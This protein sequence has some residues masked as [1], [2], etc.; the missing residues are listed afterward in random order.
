[1]HLQTQSPEIDIPAKSAFRWRFDVLKKGYWGIS[2]Y[3]SIVND[4][5]FFYKKSVLSKAFD[6]YNLTVIDGT[7]WKRAHWD[8]GICGEC[9]RYR[10]KW[11]K[12][13]GIFSVVWNRSTN[14]VRLS[15]RATFHG[16]LGWLR[17]KG[18]RTQHNWKCF[19]CRYRVLYIY[20]EYNDWKI[21]LQLNISVHESYYKTNKM[22]VSVFQRPIHLDIA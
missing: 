12:F 21:E 10:H 3:Y 19:W 1:M 4:N 6:S 14:L 7:K 16:W 15:S 22:H 20:I 8:S 17:L 11:T 5:Y 2:I 13:W 9:N 18:C